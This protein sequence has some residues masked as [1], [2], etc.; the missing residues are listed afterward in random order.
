MH[1][2]PALASA[3][4]SVLRPLV[5]ILLRNG[6]TL[7]AFVEY[8]KQI[9][10]DLASNEFGVPGRQP[11]VSRVSLLTGLTRKEVSRLWEQDESAGV[12]SAR[13]SRAAQVVSGWVRSAGFRDASGEPAELPFEGARKSFSELV[14]RFGADVPPRA[15]LDELL[16]SGAVERTAA[17]RLR[18]LTR[19]YVPRTDDAEKLGILGTDVADLISTVDHN[20]VC[21]PERAFFQRK[22]AY[23]KLVAECLPELRERAARRGQTLLE[24]L[25]AFMSAHDRDTNPSVPGTGSHRAVLGIYYYEEPMNPEDDENA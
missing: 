21:P 3:V 22:V 16:Q 9:Y 15:V 10:V 19:A 2:R 14:R 6:V 11:S 23:D 5:R 20:I 24:A 8:A 25:D 18:L 4:R 7:W 12:D 1:D 17:G 13:Y